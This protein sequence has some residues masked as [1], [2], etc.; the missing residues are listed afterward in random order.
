LSPRR[1]SR[2]ARPPGAPASAFVDS[3]AWLAFFSASDDNHPAADALFR[4]AAAAAVRLITT[5]LVLAEVH[6]LLLFRAGPRPAAAALA[7]VDASALLTITF[8]T[9][10]HHHAARAWLAKLADQ[11]ISY[12]DATSFAVMEAHKCRTAM[13]FDHDFWLAGFELWQP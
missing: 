9:E 7:R 6:R 1:P 10:A 11:R 13:A 3:G 8:T 5:N 12:T 4:R 2:A